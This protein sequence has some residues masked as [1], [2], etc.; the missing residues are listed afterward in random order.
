VARIGVLSY[1]LYLWQQPFFAPDLR[2]NFGWSLLWTLV[3]AV[4][5]Y[6]ALELPMLALRDRITGRSKKIG[7][8]QSEIIHQLH[9]PTDKPDTRFDKPKH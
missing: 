7:A 1:S 6:V 3:F 2:I 8:A 9:T 5:S 4:V